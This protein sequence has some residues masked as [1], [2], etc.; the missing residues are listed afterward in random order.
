MLV[1]KLAIIIHYHSEVLDLLQSLISLGLTPEESSIPPSIP[2]LRELSLSTD[3]KRLYIWYGLFRSLMAFFVVH[4]LGRSKCV[5]RA[6]QFCLKIVSGFAIAHRKLLLTPTLS[7]PLQPAVHRW[8][9]RWVLTTADIN[10]LGVQ[11]IKQRYEW[12]YWGDIVFR[13][14][15]C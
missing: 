4:Y 5:C 12:V 8:P 9:T 14:L 1:K 7:L 11:C 10:E 3:Y 15:F 2:Q 6:Q 13:Y